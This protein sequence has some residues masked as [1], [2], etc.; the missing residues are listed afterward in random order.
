MNREELER[1]L[2]VKGEHPGYEYSETTTTNVF[3]IESEDALPAS[4]GWELDVDAVP[5]TCDDEAGQRTEQNLMLV[6]T[7]YWRRKVKE[8]SLLE[9]EERAVGCEV[10]TDYDYVVIEGPYEVSTEHGNIAVRLARKDH[11]LDE[12][13]TPNV[14]NDYYIT[15]AG[16]NLRIK[17]FRKRQ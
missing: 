8:A 14:Y 7:L 12:G 3:S 17:A 5:A 9:L 16:Q 6:T 10:H 13:W 15:T 11:R 2:L 1:V 4:E